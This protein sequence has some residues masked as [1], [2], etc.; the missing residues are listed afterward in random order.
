MVT[1]PDANPYGAD[2]QYAAAIEPLPAGLRAMAATHYLD[3]SLSIDHI[4][5][6]F[7]NF[8]ESAFVA[9]TES[10]LRVLGLDQLA[11]WFREASLIV[12][13]LKS[14]IDE[15]GDYYECIQRHGVV[16]RLDELQKNADSLEPR[17]HGRD[18]AS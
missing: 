6:H 4:G 16:G 12:L 8:G 11:D 13:P 1:S 7:L 5:W 3:F 17:S 9:E 14:E 2:G 10:G 18:L 15:C